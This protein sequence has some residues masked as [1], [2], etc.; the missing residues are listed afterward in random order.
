MVDVAGVPVERLILRCWVRPDR[1][2]PGRWV[3]SCIELD[4]W[5]VGKDPRDAQASLHDAIQ[6]YLETVLE[7]GESASIA[8]LLERRAPFRSRLAWYVLRW[9]AELFGPRDGPPA[10][11]GS[12]KDVLPFRLATA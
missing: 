8:A 11:A 9:R 7:T 2:I 1:G 5:A 3:A 4:L 6:G 10:R 12:Y